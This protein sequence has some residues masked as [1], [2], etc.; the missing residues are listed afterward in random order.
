MDRVLHGNTACI[1]KH[2][3][4]QI[5]Y[6]YHKYHY[7]EAH[8]QSFSF[9]LLFLNVKGLKNYIRWL[10]CIINFFKV[11][12]QDIFV[13]RI[14]L[15]LEFFKNFS[16]PYSYSKVTKHYICN[17]CSI[18]SFSFKSLIYFSISSYFSKSEFLSAVPLS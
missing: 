10:I 6:K 11:F 16:N 4:H 7:N 1:S 8:F 5:K 14:L 15:I 9:F 2:Q 18:I 3:H 13:L 12:F 17:Y